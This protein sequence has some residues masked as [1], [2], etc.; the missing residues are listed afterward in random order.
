MLLSCPIVVMVSL[1][2]ST[3]SCRQIMRRR[4]VDTHTDVVV[5]IAIIVVVI[6][7]TDHI[8]VC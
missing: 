7:G 5:V 2:L 3:C 8:N 4:F 1:L 6:V